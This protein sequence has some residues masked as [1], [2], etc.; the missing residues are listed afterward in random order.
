[1]EIAS[2]LIATGV[3]VPQSSGDEAPS[4]ENGVTQTTNKA[5]LGITV[6]TIDPQTAYQYNM[7]PGVYVS[8]ITV[9]STTDAGLQVGDRILSIDDVAVSIATDV[10]GYLANK[11]PGDTVVLTVAREG[12]MLNLTIPLVANTPA[13]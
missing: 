11:N 5:I 1:M 13:E 7:M 3:Y 4:N 9:Q 6:Q 8:E 10:T 12:K 2:Q